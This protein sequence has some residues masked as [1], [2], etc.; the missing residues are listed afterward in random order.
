MSADTRAGQPAFE[1]D[2]EDV[3]YVRHGD[4]PLLA[5]IFRPRGQGPFPAVVEAHGG[6]WCIGSRVNN[7]S[8]NTPVA[9]G[10]VVVAALDFRMPPEASYPGSVADVNYG[11][12]WLKAN[13]GRFA[14]RAD[15]VG[16]MGTSSGGHL[17]VLAALKPDDPRYAAIPLPAGAPAV[18]ARVPYVATLWPV[19]C[20]LGRYRY[21]KGRQASG[22]TTLTPATAIAH[23]DAY[24][25]TE[26]AMAEGSPALAMERGD[27]VEL[28]HILYLQNPD[29]ELHPRAN[30]DQFV[31]AYGK[32]GGRV[33]LEFFAGEAYDAL[34]SHPATPASMKAVERIVA[35]IR[36]H[37]L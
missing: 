4:R 14:T 17:A 3:E 22:K 26:A 15:W 27:R 7:D 23:Q 24:W 12:R 31:A 16:T 6:A 9:R 35:F 33:E 29:D 36:S 1:V 5:R 20:P 10:G 21:M 8:I 28:P 37:A 13:A 32:A 18:D 34:R 30:L 2:I 19:I 25:I 11:I